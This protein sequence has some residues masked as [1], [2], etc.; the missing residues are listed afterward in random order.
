VP[1]R[2]QAA[3][4]R[5]DGVAAPRPEE[6]LGF[7]GFRLLHPLNHADHFDELCS[8]LGASHFRALGRGNVYGISA[9]ALALGTAEPSGE[10]FPG[11]TAFWIE[12]PAPDAAAITLHA[13]MESA[14][15][16]GAFA[17]RI[18]P[19]EGSVMHVEAQLFPR[20][21]IPRIGV[22]PMTSMFFFGPNAPPPSRWDH[23][24]AKRTPILPPGSPPRAALPRRGGR[25]ASGG[26]PAGRGDQFASPASRATRPHSSASLAMR[27]RRLSGPFAI[28]SKPWPWMVASRSGLLITAATSAASRSTIGRGVPAAQ[29]RL[30]QK[31]AA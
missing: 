21:E 29:S 19:G 22:A 5:Y 24:P 16:T 18:T 4:F 26:G 25:A 23:G 3:Q 8:F 12:R 10:E 28:G 2:F 1:I 30:D 17:M 14:S 15:V 31:L 13:L 7:A 9:R 11:F 6:D 27:C 20:R